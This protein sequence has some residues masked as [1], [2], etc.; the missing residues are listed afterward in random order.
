MAIKTK[1]FVEIYFVDNMRS[2]PIID[3]CEKNIGRRGTQWEVR[4]RRFLERNG[5]LGSIGMFEFIRAE[6]AVFFTLMWK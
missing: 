4:F 2:A 3:W 1:D 6:D 5:H